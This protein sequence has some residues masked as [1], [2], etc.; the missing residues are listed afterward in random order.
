MQHL[1]NTENEAGNQPIFFQRY[2]SVKFISGGLPEGS[3]V[4]Y[5]SYKSSD[6]SA[7]ETL[8]ISVFTSSEG[9]EEGIRIGRLSKELIN[10]TGELDLYG[11]VSVDTEQIIG[12]IFFSRLTFETD[13][14]VFI[15]SPVAV[16]S[17][18]QGKGIGQELIK[19]GLREMKRR[20]V[21]IV[22]TYGD[23][24]FYSK[25]GFLP[26]SEN[27]LKAPFEL[28]QPVGWLGQSLVGDQ[29]E[30]IPGR[31]LCVKAFNDPAYW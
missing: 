16:H 1:T 9:E 22:T 20:G 19:Y 13:I 21:K 30:A 8:F 31:P 28:S 26:L 10:N 6:T 25:V 7:I 12:A 14:D 24:A 23:P 11:F 3:I 18:H 29:I 27:V 5:R 4:E 15:L 2:V 17:G